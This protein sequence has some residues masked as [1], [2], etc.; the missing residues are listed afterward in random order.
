MSGSWTVSLTVALAVLAGSGCGT[1]ANLD[2]REHALISM[3]GAVEPKP[4][5]GVARDAQWVVNAAS[6]APEQ[7]VAGVLCSTWFVLDMP[8][9]LVGDLVTLPRVFVAAR[10]YRDQHSRASQPGLAS[11]PADPLAPQ[12]QGLVRSTRDP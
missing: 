1:M 12:P 2:G 7:P 9:S 8:F 6:C 3:P 4:L 5:G 11:P 10:E